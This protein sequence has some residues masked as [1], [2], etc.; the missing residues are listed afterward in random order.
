MTGSEAVITFSKTNKSQL[1]TYLID[2]LFYSRSQ[3]E[4]ESGGDYQFVDYTILQKFQNKCIKLIAGGG[5]WVDMY[6]CYSPVLRS[7]LIL[8]EA[9]L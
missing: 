9:H 8:R 3:Q 2:C 7:Y 4:H 1:D 5:L 6:Y